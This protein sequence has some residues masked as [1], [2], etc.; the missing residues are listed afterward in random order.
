MT[1]LAGVAG[2]FGDQ[3]GSGSNARLRSPNALAA[4]SEGNLY[5]GDSG[6][7]RKVTPAG[8]VTT[9]ADLGPATIRGLT[10]VAGSLYATAGNAVVRI[11]PVH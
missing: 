3:D 7:V 10:W 5:V 11:A 2:Q 4:E 6:R 9:I 1:I 8:I